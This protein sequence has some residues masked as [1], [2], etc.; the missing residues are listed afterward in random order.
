[1]SD[2]TW[3]RAARLLRARIATTAAA[4][5]EGFPRH[6]DPPTGEWTTTPDGDWT[7]GFWVAMCWLSARGAADGH[8]AEWARRSAERLHLR[9]PSSPAT[10][11][12]R[13]YYGALVGAVV[14]G[15][16]GA[17]SMA[18]ASA[19]DVGSTF[20]RVVGFCTDGSGVTSIATVPGV[21]LLVWAARESGRPEWQAIAAEH[22]RRHIELCIRP[23]GAVWPSVAFDP[24]TG[25]VI[26]RYSRKGLHDNSAWARGQAWAI[27]GYTLL[28]QWTG[29]PHFRDVAQRAADW[30]LANSSHDHVAFWDFDDPAS[31]NATRDTSASA[32][33]AAALLKLAVLATETRRAVYRREADGIATALVERFLDQRGVLSHGCD[34]KP[35]KV[36]TKHELIWGSYYLLEAVEVLA[37]R[38]PP[39]AI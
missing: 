19:R 2:A 4:V 24:S 32:I 30:W 36:A 10:G 5:G 12:L 7:G 25:A 26:R 9:Q 17:R 14:A 11:G 33:V 6:A 3:E 37:G 16:A 23:T 15:D 29:D 35:Q 13:A 1:M 27:L 8:Y 20:D 31:F 22:A 39:T 18:L 34:D 21:A 38:L 28:H